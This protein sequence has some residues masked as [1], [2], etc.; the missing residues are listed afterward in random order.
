MNWY[1]QGKLTV[2]QLNDPTYPDAY[3]TSVIPS[4]AASLGLPSQH[5]NIKYLRLGRDGGYGTQ[6]AFPTGYAGNGMFKLRVSEDTAFLNW[7]SVAT[8]TSPQRMKLP[9]ANGFVEE[10]ASEYWRTQE[11]IVMSTFRMKKADGSVIPRGS[12]IVATFPKGFRPVG[13]AAHGSGTVIPATTAP[14][15]L[16][17]VN[18][19]GDAATSG[20][21]YV[22]VNADNVTSV[23]GSIFF[24]TFT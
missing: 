19:D 1:P 5:W 7:I 14:P 22:H 20:A 4:G 10:F 17:S 8:A 23:T 2:A 21:L 6:L 9:L 3:E 16:I 15:C 11:G 24:D 18:S 12:H 13:Y